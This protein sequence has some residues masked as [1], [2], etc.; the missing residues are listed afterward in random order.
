MTEG[1]AIALIFV[2]MLIVLTGVCIILGSIHASGTAYGVATILVGGS[3]AHVSSLVVVH[4]G[5]SRRRRQR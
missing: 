4:Y 5:P 2:A 1:K 3:G